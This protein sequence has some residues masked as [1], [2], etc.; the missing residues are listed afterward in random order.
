MSTNCFQIATAKKQ[1]NAPNVKSK[2]DKKTNGERKLNSFVALNM[3]TS[4][5]KITRKLKELKEE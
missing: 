3:T 4:I 5:M 1:E 2:T